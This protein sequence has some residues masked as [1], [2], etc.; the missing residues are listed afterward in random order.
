MDLDQSFL[1]FI[2]SEINT[3]IDRILFYIFVVYA[4]KM[5]FQNKYWLF[6]LKFEIGDESQKQIMMKSK[7]GD[8]FK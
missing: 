4:F 2:I 3:I 6:W 5:T 7:I 1:R 8:S